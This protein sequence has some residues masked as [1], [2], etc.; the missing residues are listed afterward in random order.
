VLGEHSMG[1]LA[2]VRR[3]GHPRLSTVAYAWDAERRIARIS[4][5]ADRAKVGITRLYGTSLD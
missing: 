2:T 4:T 1:A 5:S 3:S